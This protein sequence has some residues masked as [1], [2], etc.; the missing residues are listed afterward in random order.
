M[1][2]SIQNPT[3]QCTIAGN[4]NFDHRLIGHTSLDRL[5]GHICNDS[6]VETRRLRP[7]PHDQIP[8]AGIYR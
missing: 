3:I 4:S 5:V 1:G 7:T 8:H 6:A 2:N